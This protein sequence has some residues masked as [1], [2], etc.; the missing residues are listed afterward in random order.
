MKWTGMAALAVLSLAGVCQANDPVPAGIRMTNPRSPL[1]TAANWWARFGEPVNQEAIDAAPMKTPVDTV[2]YSENGFGYVYGPGSCDYTPPCTDWQWKDYNPMPWRC[3]PLH[4]RLKDRHG[5][6][7]HCGN[8][9]NDC[10]CGHGHGRL[11]CGKH[12]KCGCDDAA[13]SCDA[14]APSC[15]AAPSCEAVADCG[16]DVA[17]SCCKKRHF[18]WHWK[19]LGFWNKHCGCDTC[20]PS[21]GAE[22]AC[23][24]APAKELSSPEQ[25]PQP[26]PDDAKA[27]AHTQPTLVWP[28]G[29]VR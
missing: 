24:Y 5:H 17:T 22:P 10:G 14:K 27:A 4:Q 21:C 18:H 16:C 13:P 2:G 23:D 29:P 11:F 26:I 9:G 12:N 28:L 8:C 1:H 19:G 7:G 6:C 15:A 20:A 25:A 3:Y